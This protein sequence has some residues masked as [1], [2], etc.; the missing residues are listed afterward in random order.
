MSFKFEGTD[1]GVV[2]WNVGTSDPGI[3]TW[4][5]LGATAGQAFQVQ[6]ILANIDAA[7]PALITTAFGGEAA[8]VRTFMTLRT[9]RTASAFIEKV[10]T[11]ARRK[12]AWSN[13]F[14]ALGVNRQARLQYDQLMDASATA[15]IPEAIADFTRAF[16]RQC[17][18]PT[19]YERNLVVA[20]VR[21][22]SMEHAETAPSL[23]T[24]ELDRV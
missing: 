2:E 4:G 21:K 20:Q 17:L 11:D 22:E 1:Y 5:P 23:L 24:K 14:S 9:E 18:A 12:T 3:L 8:A 19:E 16:W 7:Q 13:G 6:R 15:G 10:A